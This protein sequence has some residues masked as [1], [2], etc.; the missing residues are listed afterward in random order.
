MAQAVGLK[1]R[2]GRRLFAIFQVLVVSFLFMVIA[3]LAEVF[4]Q[5]IATQAGATRAA[6][7]Q[8]RITKWL[9]T[10]GAAGRATKA[11][12]VTAAPA[13][14]GAI[15]ANRL[16]TTATAVPLIFVDIAA[17]ILAR[18]AVPTIEFHEGPSLGIRVE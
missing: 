9:L 4:V 11:E 14:A 18:D 6:P 12:G 10:L 17:T 2:V 13:A 1:R 16:I 3:L 15:G 7:L 8:T 5:T